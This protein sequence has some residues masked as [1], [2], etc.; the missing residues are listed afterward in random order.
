ML[1]AGQ[2]QLQG[3]LRI[4]TVNAE[5][6]ETKLWSS[7]KNQITNLH[8]TNL[9][10]LITQRSTVTVSELAFNSMKIEANVTPFPSPPSPSDTGP[11]GTVVKTYVFDRDLDVQIN[12]GGTPG[13]VQFRA[14]VDAAEA[15]GSILRAAGIY[16][17]GDGLGG[18]ER[19][20]A[21]QEYTAITKTAALG[22]SFVWDIQYTIV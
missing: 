11:T 1:K 9:A 20:V 5:T 13:L 19:L 14:T 4:Y 12:V 8:L 2:L 15:N 22:I 6:G 18:G 21:R 17:S 7:K 10:D 16:T 3:H